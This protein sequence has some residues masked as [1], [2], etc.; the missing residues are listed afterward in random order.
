[1]GDELGLT[2][3]EVMSEVNKQRGGYIC[4]HNLKIVYDTLVHRCD[5]LEHPADEEEANELDRNKT[6]FI[7]AFLLFLVGVTIFANKN[8]KNV[9]MLWLTMLQDLDTVQEWSWGGMTLDFLYTQLSIATD[10]TIGVVSGY[11]SLLE[12][13]KN[14]FSITYYI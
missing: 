10:P 2:E 14:F 11:M 8:N 4:K 9:H 6:M 3:E 1:M 13:K 7:K 5:E 12:V